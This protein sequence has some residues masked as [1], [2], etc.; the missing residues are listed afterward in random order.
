MRLDRFAPHYAVA[1]VSVVLL[2][3]LSLP[4]MSYSET[5]ALER[6]LT[7]PEQL[8]FML[9]A[10]F[11][12]CLAHVDSVLDPIPN[13]LGIVRPL[14]VLVVRPYKWFTPTQPKLS[15]VRV[16]VSPLKGMEIAA[17]LERQGGRLDMLIGLRRNYTAEDGRRLS[18][19]LPEA[20]WRM[21]EESFALPV[22]HTLL[23]PR[24]P[25]MRAALEQRIAL[26]QSRLSLQ[27]LTDQADLIVVGSLDESHARR[28]F[29]SSGDDVSFYAID[30]TLAGTTPYK[31]VAVLVSPPRRMPNS[32]VLLFLKHEAEDTYRVVG[33]GHGLMGIEDG[34]VR[35]LEI[36]LNSAVAQIATQ[37]AGGEH[38]SGR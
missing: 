6:P 14:K 11:A 34:V 8:Q 21:G 28:Y 37:R 32:R 15:H 2:A 24:N 12:T 33:M 16:R 5:A 9:S 26:A 22:S 10:S 29:G 27:S 30:T 38:K 4:S 3:L 1:L 18:A 25:A 20:P 31:T 35:K 17:A 19:P 7:A 13:K 36:P 23:D